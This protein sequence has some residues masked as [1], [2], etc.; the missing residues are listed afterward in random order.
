ML[1]IPLTAG[2]LSALVVAHL[3]SL[4]AAGRLGGLSGDI[5]GACSELGEMFFL[6]GFYIF[7]RVDGL[8]GFATS[9]FQAVISFVQLL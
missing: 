4:Y 9:T 2:C 5:L 7:L 1:L 6:L 3:L 8:D